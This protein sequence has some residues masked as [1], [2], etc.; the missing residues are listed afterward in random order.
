MQHDLCLRAAA[1][2]I[3]D[4]VYPSEDWAPVGF[5]EAE[6]R[7]TIH[8]RQ[9]VEAAQIARPLFLAG[10]EEQPTLF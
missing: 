2:A 9:S 3:Y 1:R 6:K 8:Y 4:T 10:R 7:G 5:D